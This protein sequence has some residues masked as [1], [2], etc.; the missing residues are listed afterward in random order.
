MKKSIDKE[1]GREYTNVVSQIEKLDINNRGLKGN[2]NTEVSVNYFKTNLPNKLD[3]S[4]INKFNQNLLSNKYWGN[5]KKAV[6]L[7]GD[8]ME[9]RKPKVFNNISLSNTNKSAIVNNTTMN[10]YSSL[11]KP[12]F[13]DIIINKLKNSTNVNIGTLENMNNNL[14]DSRLGSDN[15]IINKRLNNEI[16]TGKYVKVEGVYLDTEISKHTRLKHKLLPA[17]DDKDDFRI[18]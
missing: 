6:D 8:R 2:N 11:I 4:N 16:N 1:T 14:N 7:L 15:K 13:K 9:L 3:L 17:S 5:D 10:N 18:N 12:S